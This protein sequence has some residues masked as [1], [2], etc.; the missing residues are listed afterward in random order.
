MVQAL[1]KSGS[2]VSHIFFPYNHG[3]S[4]RNEAFGFGSPW[5]FPCIPST[6][7][8]AETIPPC[9]PP[10]TKLDRGMRWSAPSFPVAPYV[11]L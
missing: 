4:F 2:Q 6:I 5:V 3:E 10:F 8:P 11:E 7:A 1:P 9:V